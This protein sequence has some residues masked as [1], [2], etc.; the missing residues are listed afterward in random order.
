[1]AFISLPLYTLI[2][3]VHIKAT[4]GS[5]ALNI[6]FWWP[7]M[8]PSHTC[9]PLGQQP[10]MVGAAIGCSAL[11]E[12]PAPLLHLD[13]T[14]AD[15]R[16][17]EAALGHHLPAVWMPIL[18]LL[19]ISCITFNITLGKVFKGASF[20]A[21]CTVGSSSILT[22]SF[23]AWKGLP[24]QVDLTHGLVSKIIRFLCFSTVVI[25]L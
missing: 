9:L 13:G 8:D 6:L 12:L 11:P 25:S 21:H 24:I 19:V 22:P 20:H 4:L 7:L 23:R 18:S 5:L 3:D 16:A 17:P 2:H 14:L 10:S 15:W 1:M